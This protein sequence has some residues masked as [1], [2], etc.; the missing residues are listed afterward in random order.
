MPA[1]TDGHEE[2]FEAMYKSFHFFHG[3]RFEFYGE[4]PSA[5]AHLA[6]GQFKL[7]KRRMEWVPDALYFWVTVQFFD[8]PLGTF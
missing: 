5:A 2:S 4:K 8:K 1:P 7:W 3:I 6:F